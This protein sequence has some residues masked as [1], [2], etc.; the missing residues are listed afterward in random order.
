MKG[1]KILLLIAVVGMINAFSFTDITDVIGTPPSP[2]NGLFG[3]VKYAGQLVM[4][5][6][7]AV[8]TIMYYS[9]YG[10]TFPGF[11]MALRIPLGLLFGGLFVYGLIDTIN[12][13][14]RSWKPGV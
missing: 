8:F 7:N 13:I 2:G 14:V 1:L 6:F 3:M 12:S 4:Y 11:P 5:M 10:I 9:L